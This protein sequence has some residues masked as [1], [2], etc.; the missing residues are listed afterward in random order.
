MPLQGA[1]VWIQGVV[2]FGRTSPFTLRPR[3]FGEQNVMGDRVRSLETP[4]T[5]LMWPD[6]ELSLLFPP[7]VLRKLL[8]KDDET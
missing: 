4:L 1:H 8:Y 2:T 3:N 6:R 5:L 7:E